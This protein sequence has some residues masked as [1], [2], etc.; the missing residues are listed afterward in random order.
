MTFVNQCNCPFH[1]FAIR[2]KVIDGIFTTMYID[3]FVHILNFKKNS[4]VKKTACPIHPSTDDLMHLTHDKNNLFS[5]ED[6]RDYERMLYILIP[7]F[8]LFL[9]WIRSLCVEPSKCVFSVA[10]ADASCSLN[11]LRGFQSLFE[12]L[13]IN[14][15]KTDKIQTSF[16]PYNGPLQTASQDC[17][18]WFNIDGAKKRIVRLQQRG[19][20]KENLNNTRGQQAALR[21]RDDITLKWIMC[22]M[23]QLLDLEQK[24]SKELMLH[25]NTCIPCMSDDLLRMIQSY[26]II[27]RACELA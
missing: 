27:P 3:K 25:L 14:P 10:T 24:I 18:F 4:I 1:E 5:E 12:K 26:D 9:Q 16:I 23:K 11:T 6:F 8:D 13:W 15:C 19:D 7:R 22:K 17:D 20:L 2:L 21:P